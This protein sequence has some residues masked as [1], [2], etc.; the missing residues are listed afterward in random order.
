MAEAHDFLSLLFGH[1]S[2]SG[3]LLTVWDRQTHHTHTFE[4]PVRIRYTTETL[5]KGQ[6]TSA[7]VGLGIRLLLSRV[8]R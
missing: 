8:T 6:R 5:A 4:L 1:P 2:L 3:L 7:A